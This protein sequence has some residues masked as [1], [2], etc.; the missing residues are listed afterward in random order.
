LRLAPNLQVAQVDSRQWAIDARGFNNTSA[1]KLLVMMDGRTL[2]TPLFAGVFWDVQDTLMEDIDRIEVISGPGATLWGANAVNGVINIITKSAKD[3][4][5]F[6]AEAGGG[7]LLRDFVGA[8]YGGEIGKDLYFRVYG[9]YFDRDSTVTPSGREGT[10][11]WRMGQG[12]F[13]ADYLPSS[14]DIVTLQGDGYGGDFEQAAPGHGGLNGQNI[15]GRWTH[16]L[17]NDSEMTFQAYWDRTYRNIPNLFKETLNTFDLDFQHHFPLGSWLDI[18]W[19]GGYRAMLDRVGNS[20]GLAFVP[21]ER[22]LQLV[23]AFL[24]GEIELVPERLKLTLG[25]KLEHNDYSGFEAEPSGR[26]AW[27]PSEKQ[28]FWAAASRAVR[29]PSRIDNDLFFPGVPPFVIGGG[30]GFRSEKLV[31][32]EA[33]YRIRPMERLTL[34]LAGYYNFYDDIRSLDPVGTNG[35]IVEYIIR[36]GNRAKAGGVELSGTWQATDWWRL[37]GGYSYLQ[38]HVTIKPGGSDLNRGRAEGN[39]PEHQ[40][41]LQSMIDLPCHFE[42]DSVFRY[43]AELPDPNV[44]GYFTMDLR[45]AWH[46]TRNFEVSIVGQNL[47]DDRHPEFGPIATRQEI[48]RSVYGKLAWHF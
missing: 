6:F 16:P 38:K 35:T 4:P 1:N 14:G 19:G 37:R 18:I 17:A 5:G 46:P 22:N 44:P 7:T 24:Q 21:A 29:A 33:G 48:P 39:D 20:A 45:L 42:F 28:T 27:T 11:D 2:Y 15:L 10:N 8:R 25:S 31:A 9:K 23:S 3:T 26:L 32:L 47:V 36:N 43:V 41:V 12:G 40:F 30:E 34:S 13:R